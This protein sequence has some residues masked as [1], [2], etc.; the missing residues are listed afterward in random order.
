MFA[1]GEASFIS[2]KVHY[3]SNKQSVVLNADN[4]KDER[5]EVLVSILD[6]NGNLA[7]K[8]ATGSK[9]GIISNSNIDSA[10]GAKEFSVN[11]IERQVKTDKYNTIRFILDYTII[12]IDQAGERGDIVTV[13][14]A[15]LTKKI[16]IDFL[17]AN[18]KGLVVRVANS[19]I[20]PA[21]Y[22]GK[23]FAQITPDIDNNLSIHSKTFAGGTVGVEVPIKIY[24]STKVQDKGDGKG[25]LVNG[26][27]TRAS[28]M[29]GK[30]VVVTALADYNG[31]GVANIVVAQKEGYMR[32]GI[33]DMEIA[34]TKGLPEDEDNRH[35][36]FD[37]NIFNGLGIAFIAYMK[38]DIS[39]SNIGDNLQNID[40]NDPLRFKV[41]GDHNATDTTIVRSLY[42]SDIKIGVFDRESLFLDKQ[43]SK[44]YTNYYLF[45]DNDTSTEQNMTLTAIDRYG[46]PARRASSAKV[47]CDYDD[48][49]FKIDCRDRFD[50]DKGEISSTMI[51]LKPSDNI[52]N[53]DNINTVVREGRRIYT[54]LKIQGIDGISSAKALKT[55]V[56]LARKTTDYFNFDGYSKNLREAKVVFRNSDAD[57]GYKV[58][59]SQVDVNGSLMKV[60]IY[61]R[62]LNGVYLD[63]DRSNAYNIKYKGSSTIDFARAGDTKLGGSELSIS[64]VRDIYIPVYTRSD[65]A[66]RDGFVAYVFSEDTQNK[67][68]RHVVLL[69]SSNDTINTSYESTLPPG[70]SLRFTLQGTNINSGDYIFVDYNYDYAN[71]GLSKNNPILKTTSYRRS[72]GDFVG[73]DL[74]ISVM[75]YTP[76]KGAYPFSIYINGKKVDNNQVVSLATDHIID[77]KERDGLHLKVKFQYDEVNSNRNT[78]YISIVELGGVNKGDGDGSV[79]NSLLTLKD[80]NG[81]G[82]IDTSYFNG[83]HIN[84]VVYKGVVYTNKYYLLFDEDKDILEQDEFLNNLKTDKGS[85]RTLQDYSYSISGDG[86][87]DDDGDGDNV[88]V[89]FDKQD[90]GSEVI[91]RIKSGSAYNTIRFTNI[92]ASSNTN[93]FYIIAPQKATPQVNLV[94]TEVI[95]KIIGNAKGQTDD[96]IVNLSHSNKYATMDIIPIGESRESLEASYH[97]DIE[98]RL[99]EKGNYY[100]IRTDKPGYITIKATGVEVNSRGR[101]ESVSS[102][103]ELR[104]VNFDVKS[105]IADAFVQGNRVSIVIDDDSLDYDRSIIEARDKD[106]K[107][108]KKAIKQANGN[109]IIYDLPK[110]IYQIYVYAIDAFD[111][112]FTN[113][114]T[115][116]ITSNEYIPSKEDIAEKKDKIIQ[117]TKAVVLSDKMIEHPP[118]LLKGKFI[119]YKFGDRE[120]LNWMFH[121]DSSKKVYKLFSTTSSIDPFGLE[122]FIPDFTKV[123]STKW[124]Y[125]IELDGAIGTLDSQDKFG[126]VVVS[127]DLKIVKKVET[128]T[129]EGLLRYKVLPLKARKESGRIVFIFNN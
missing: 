121:E 119:Y 129:K 23:K 43:W 91:V 88:Y 81:D 103:K 58:V 12:D 110:G 126:W 42:A 125:L 21:L 26:V 76:T 116:E 37:K 22:Q 97:T 100:I 102:K 35:I 11:D 50:E 69:S 64:G 60:K 13:D 106:G 117:D 51:F 112:I 18:A 40:L 115:R 8:S 14:V 2:V 57:F 31:D 86:E 3:L 1:L 15:G 87:I 84:E 66:L 95:V 77:T 80:I 46:N 114:Y 45:D 72:I 38:D 75:G 29:E 16:N 55:V 34:I 27:F 68:D 17:Y 67:V 120:Y 9:L 82:E 99:K 7:T 30:S 5:I 124:W 128:I 92:V 24:A 53:K 71:I 79:K 4:D 6:K 118:Y 74:A 70:E 28:D 127:N 104:F 39:I 113:T 41:L 63:T 47:F 56:Y 78:K 73:N 61:E 62:L 109:Y 96:F 52:D 83:N 54:K 48:E 101:R 20:D 94:N 33:V 107:T 108:I 32:N 25:T 90:V 65:S 89:Q 49:Y 123:D 19:S 10:V 93:D 44:P 59:V 122:E 36:S 98:T 85:Y 105:P 111:N